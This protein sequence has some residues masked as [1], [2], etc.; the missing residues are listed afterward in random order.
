METKEL[1]SDQLIKAQQK[2]NK[3]SQKM[4]RVL[5]LEDLVVRNNKLIRINPDGTEVIVGDSK[6]KS[7]KTN[8]GVFQIKSE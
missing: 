2:A 5:G 7:V 8:K 4:I 3:N 1:N 6:F